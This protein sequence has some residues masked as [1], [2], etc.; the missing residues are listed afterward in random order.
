MYILV[1]F[2]NERCPHFEAHLKLHIQNPRNSSFHKHQL[3]ALT[4]PISKY[5][6]RRVGHYDQWMGCINFN[7]TPFLPL[8]CPLLLPCV[9]GS[10]VWKGGTV[11]I[12]PPFESSW[13]HDLLWPMESGGCDVVLVLS[14]KQL[15][16]LALF[17]G[18][19]LQWHKSKPRLTCW[20]WETPR[21]NLSIP[22]LWVKTTW[23]G[24]PS[25]SP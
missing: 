22:A 18:A 15:W 7:M 17:L 11:S 16:A 8:Q 19:T 13:P 10:L 9:M 21:E 5:N 14:L 6:F 24:Q 12:S 4:W 2:E 23:T 3:Q 25:A 1:M 20:R